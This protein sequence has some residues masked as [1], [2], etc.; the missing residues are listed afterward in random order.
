MIGSHGD[1]L[2]TFKIGF[3]RFQ[4]DRLKFILVTSKIR[5]NEEFLSTI[6][7]S[8]SYE[9]TSLH[10]KK[11]IGLFLRQISARKETKVTK[12]LFVGARVTFWRA[13]NEEVKVLFYDDSSI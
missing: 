9:R 5:R 12:T 7:D 1:Y 13:T 3:N 4:S 2:S 8:S 10:S 11:E 6:L